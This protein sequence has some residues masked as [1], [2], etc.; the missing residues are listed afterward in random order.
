MKAC[1]CFS[2]RKASRFKV[3]KAFKQSNDPEFES[4]KNRILELYVIADRTAV[5]DEVIQRWCS[6]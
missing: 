3:I 6:A 2:E 5:P 1:G 4:K